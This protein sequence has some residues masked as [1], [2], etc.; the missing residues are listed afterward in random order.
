[1][2]DPFENNARTPVSPG[3]WINITPADSDLTNDLKAILVGTDGDLR[4]TSV[5]PDGTEEDETISSGILATGV[6]HPGHIRRVWSTSTTASNILGQ[7]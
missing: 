7:Y 1:M 6:W 5:A 4:V 2:A 3:A